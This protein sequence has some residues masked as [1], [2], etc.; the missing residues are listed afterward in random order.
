[1]NTKT[2]TF[3]CHECDTRGFKAFMLPISYLWFCTSCWAKH[4]WNPKEILETS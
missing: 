3:R 2:D 1:M 4:P